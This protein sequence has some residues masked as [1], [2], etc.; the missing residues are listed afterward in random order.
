[1]S[2]HAVELT[3]RLA[4]TSRALPPDELRRALLPQLSRIV[5]RA[6]R[7]HAE[8]VSRRL[9]DELVGAGDVLAVTGQLCDRIVARIQPRL[10]TARAVPDTALA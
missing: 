8:G 3:Q 2:A 5:R 9:R 4:G 7:P 1:M 10:E 6:R